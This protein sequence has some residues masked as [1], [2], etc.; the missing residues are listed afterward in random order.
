MISNDERARIAAYLEQLLKVKVRDRRIR[1]IQV[2]SRYHWQPPMLIEVGNLYG[3]LEP[4]APVEEVTAIFES[5]VFCVCTPSR[6]SGSGMPYLFHRG[7]VTR[8][9]DFD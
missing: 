9:V 7:D 3:D 6:G 2:N 5:T 4:G 8:V 1:A